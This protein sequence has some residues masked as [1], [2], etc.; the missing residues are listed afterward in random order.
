[1]KPTE[2]RVAG[3]ALALVPGAKRGQDIINLAGLNAGE[4]LVLEIQGDVDVAVHPNDV[5]I[6]RGNEQFSVGDGDPPLPDNP[7]LRN[8]TSATLNGAPMAS[9]GHY[10][11]G[12]ATVDQLLAWAGGGHQDVWVDL[13]GLAD[14]LLVAGDRI[15]LQG[16]DQ[17][18]TVPRDED[19]RLYTV[20]VLFDGEG[21]DRRFPASMTVLQA[22]RQSLPVSDR[23]H[24]NDFLI[25]DKNLGT[26]PLDIALTL[27]A[28]GV[29]DGHVLSI[30]KKNG[31]GG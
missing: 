31:G 8:P 30:T 20:T 16:R 1:M 25:V 22:L 17:F 5:I 12:K 15:V 14:E 3:E 7:V 6:I 10:R 9:L 11:H 2:I 13:D 26:S 19:D 27:K 28:A 4:Q 21:K 18:I 29:R 24:V 23:A